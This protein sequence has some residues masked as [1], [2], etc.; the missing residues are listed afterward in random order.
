M[1]LADHLL[2]R[3]SLRHASTVISHERHLPIDVGRFTMEFFTVEEKDY[4]ASF[5]RTHS[6]TL[7]H[8]NE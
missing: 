4:H 6:L 1:S 5:L 8:L 3:G 2:K 7:S